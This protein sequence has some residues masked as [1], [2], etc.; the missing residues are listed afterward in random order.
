MNPFRAQK[1][2]PG[3]YVMVVAALLVCVALVVW[4]IR[5]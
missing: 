3:D 2:R 4:A 1:R 5:G